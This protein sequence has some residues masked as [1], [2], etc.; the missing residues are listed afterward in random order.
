MIDMLQSEAPD[1]LAELLRIEIPPSNDRLNVPVILTADKADAQSLNRTPVEQF[2]DERVHNISGEM[3]KFSELYDRFVEWADAADAMYWTKRKFG[4]SIPSKYPK[5]RSPETGHIFI[6]NASWESFKGGVAK[7]LLR[8]I[9]DDKG[10][11]YLRP[12]P[13]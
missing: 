6:G 4:S 1:F 13:K 7:P 5:G 3:I 10:E 2:F 11:F 9:A 8:A 12:E